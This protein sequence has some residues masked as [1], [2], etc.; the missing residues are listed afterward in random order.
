[1]QNNGVA[2]GYIS[3][4]YSGGYNENSVPYCY[5]AKRQSVKIAMV[6]GGGANDDN[7]CGL[8]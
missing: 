2:V 5:D 7:N 6:G 8:Q 4:A 3:E 1:M